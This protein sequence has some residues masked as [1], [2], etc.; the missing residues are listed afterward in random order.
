MAKGAG[1]GEWISLLS[2]E[3][4]YLYKLVRKHL[5]SA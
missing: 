3:Y 5:I 2:W 1:E 4:E